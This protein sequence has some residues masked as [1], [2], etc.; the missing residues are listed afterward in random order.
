V[1]LTIELFTKLKGEGV[2]IE[3]IQAKLNEPAFDFEKKG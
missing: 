3:E 1:K 2:D